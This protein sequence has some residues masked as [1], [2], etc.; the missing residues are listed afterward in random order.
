ML[1][2]GALAWGPGSPL[3]APDLQRS[4]WALC[5]EAKEGVCQPG[6][7][8]GTHPQLHPI[9]ASPGSEKGWLGLAAHTPLFPWQRGLKVL[10]SAQQWSQ[11][12]TGAVATGCVTLR[13]SLN[14]SEPTFSTT[15]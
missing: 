11:I 6:V 4:H 14:F 15:V 9:W 3:K 10:S 5:L 8:Q 12:Q 1:L 13:S 2:G 7:N